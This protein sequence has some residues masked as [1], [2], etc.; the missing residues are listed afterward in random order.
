MAA[1]LVPEII[2]GELL[3]KEGGEWQLK[4]INKVF[5]DYYLTISGH[6]IGSHTEVAFKLLP[7]LRALLKL[8]YKEYVKD[9]KTGKKL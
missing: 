7:E 3:Q 4:S 6:L 1:T 9:S 8:L 2:H 5:I